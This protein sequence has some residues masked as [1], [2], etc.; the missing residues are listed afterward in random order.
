MNKAL[1]SIFFI[2]F[3]TF[4]SISQRIDWVEQE[5]NTVFL[6]DVDSDGN[7]FK[8]A[9]FSSTFYYNHGLDSLEVQGQNNAAI[10]KTDSLN[11][12]VWVRHLKSLANQ[13]SITGISIDTA[14]NAYI[15]GYFNATGDFSLDGTASQLMTSL[16][17]SDVFVLKIDKDGNFIWVKQLEGIGLDLADQIDVSRDGRV[18]FAGRFEETIDLDPGVGVYNSTA[19]INASTPDRDA[20][21]VMLNSAGNFQWAS[22]FQT[23]GYN[24]FKKII[25]EN[26]TTIMLSGQFGNGTDIAPGPLVVYPNVPGSVTK[27]EILIRINDDGNYINQFHSSPLTS[28][29]IDSQGYI[30]LSGVTIS[31]YFDFF[32][33]QGDTIYNDANNTPYFGFAAKVDENFNV[34]WTSM[35]GLGNSRTS[36]IAVDLI[37]NVFTMSNFIGSNQLLVYSTSDTTLVNTDQIGNT[38]IT[39]LDPQGELLWYKNF[40]GNWNLNYF[41]QE[42]QMMPSGSIYF[43]N[44]FFDTVIVSHLEECGLFVDEDNDGVLIGKLANSNCS[45]LE[46]DIPSYYCSGDACADSVVFECTPGKFSQRPINY[47]WNNNTPT[48]DS[49]YITHTPGLISLIATDVNDCHLERTFVLESPTFETDLT[50][51]LVCN[52]HRPGFSLD[53]WIDA[54]NN[55][56]IPQDGQLKLILDGLVIYNYANPIPDDI[57]GDTLI[58]NFSGATY[59]QQHI[60]PYINAYI[61]T[62]AQIGD[63]LCH[64]VIITPY[65]ND[66]DTTNNKKTYCYPVVNGYDPNDKKIYPSGKCIP[67][68]VDASKNVIYTIRFQ[69]TGNS[70]AI[71]IFILDTL[72]GHLDLTDMKIMGQSHPMNFEVLGNNVLKFNFDNINL[73]DSSVSQIESQGYV[74][75]EIGISDNAMH[76]DEIRNSASIYFD[77][78]PPI[79]TNST[80]NAVFDSELY[81]D[82]DELDCSEL[83]LVN[84]SSDNQISIFPNPT[85]GTLN[86]IS[87]TSEKLEQIIIIDIYGREV[88]KL[89]YEET[90]NLDLVSGSYLIKIELNK[91]DYIVNRLIVE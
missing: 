59:L 88:L 79:Y 86:I 74:I 61:T 68:Y 3:V 11:Q 20:F 50:S 36:T 26:D 85:N 55:G 10:I 37:G 76:E 6:D 77:F 48:L 45:S 40:K 14:D 89:P 73:P 13:M 21:I 44:S 16:G 75:F 60:V 30:Y 70:E 32:H 58:W 46:L 19:I 9:N 38:I 91:E 17:S 82:L 81:G 8:H 12:V 53:L 33:I 35:L 54:L 57:I 43:K 51:N 15:L 72:S 84:L 49:I 31:P 65:L 66:M 27:R 28:L 2:L 7:L 1:L 90:I 42:I 39:K 64:T 71:N 63:T 41:P 87:N 52:N 29:D 56:C 23:E 80:L 47:T 83:G 67:N 24:K 18:L 22:S 25:W 78:N 5:I 62:Q 4:F 69:N 34:I